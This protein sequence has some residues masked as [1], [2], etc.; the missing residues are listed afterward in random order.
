MK[1]CGIYKITKIAKERYKTRV[2]DMEG[3]FI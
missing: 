1:T 2:K 3:K